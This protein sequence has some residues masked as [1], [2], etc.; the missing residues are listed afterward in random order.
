[1][2]ERKIVTEP[3]KIIKRGSSAT[4]FL[5]CTSTMETYLVNPRLPKSMISKWIAIPMS[6]SSSVIHKQVREE[7]KNIDLGS[8]M[9]DIIVIFRTMANIVIGGS[10]FCVCFIKFQKTYMVNILLGLYSQN[11]KWRKLVK[12]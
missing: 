4:F 10:I 11:K 5:Q 9:G 12:F 1:M 3:A 8:T 7:E 6:K 2:R